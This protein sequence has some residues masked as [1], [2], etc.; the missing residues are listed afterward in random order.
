M[1]TSQ[2]IRKIKCP[3]C[4]WI[5]RMT[6]QVEDN[7]VIVTAGYSDWIGGASEALQKVLADTKGMLE[8]MELNEPNAWIDMPACPNPDCGKMYQFNMRTSDTK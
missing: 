8:D 7:E 6:I 3:H 1:P 4:G 2:Q 5:R